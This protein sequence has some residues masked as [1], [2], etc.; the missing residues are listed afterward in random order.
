M[1]LAG[2]VTDIFHPVSYPKFCYFIEAPIYCENDPAQECQEGLLG[3]LLNRIRTGLIGIMA[4]I[5][6]STSF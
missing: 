2:V 6:R 1:A 3:S 4:L 5:S